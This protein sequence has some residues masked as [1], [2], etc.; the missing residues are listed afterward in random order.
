MVVIFCILC[1]FDVLKILPVG[2]DCPSQGQ[3]VLGDSKGLMP[4]TGTPT[5]PESLP[6]L[7]PLSNAHIP[8]QYSTWTKITPGP[9]SRQLET[10]PVAQACPNYSNWSILNC[11]LCLHSFPLETPIK[12]MTWAFHLHVSVCLLTW[13]L[14]CGPVWHGRSPLLRKCT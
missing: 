11:S 4:F 14:P 5:D 8:S 7:S 3:P 2:R 13:H 6:Q 9:G 12:A 10:T 1:C